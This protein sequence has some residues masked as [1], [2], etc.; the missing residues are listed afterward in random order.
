MNH[1]M[2]EKD[3]SSLDDVVLTMH[4][5]VPPPSPWSPTCELLSFIELHPHSSHDP[6]VGTIACLFPKRSTRES[7][8]LSFILLLCRGKISE[9]IAFI[10]CR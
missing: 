8:E 3:D 1:R 5:C 10:G 7:L 4:V 9:Y 2:S 6:L